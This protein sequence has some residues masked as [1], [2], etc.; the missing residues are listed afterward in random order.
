MMIGSNYISYEYFPMKSSLINEAASIIRNEESLTTYNSK[1]SMEYLREEVMYDFVSMVLD[2]VKDALLMLYEKLVMFVNKYIV[3]SARL[4]EKYKEMIV[5][6][7]EKYKDNLKHITVTRFS[8]DKV[9]THPKV[10]KVDESEMEKL[11]ETLEQ[12]MSRGI[13]YNSTRLVYSKTRDIC[14]KITDC[15]SLNIDNELSFITKD[16][17]DFIRGPVITE[18]ITSKNLISYINNILK[19]SELKK[20]VYHIKTDVIDYYK[21]LKKM[22][23]NRNAKNFYKNIDTVSN[24]SSTGSRNEAEVLAILSANRDM[25][26]EM[27]SSIE[28]MFDTIIKVYN[29]AFNAKMNVMHEYIEKMSYIIAEIMRG[30]NIFYDGDSS[31]KPLKKN[32]DTTDLAIENELIM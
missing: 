1:Y 20:D 18:T 26:L 29:A 8:Y 17:S 21:K 31:E 32:Y 6:R 7:Y 11:F 16:Y 4:V 23:S 27:K 13:S 15:P 19:Y 5:D 22:F 24:I 10:F 30:C 12:N 14:S 3:N 25:Y 2:K 28:Y 9:K